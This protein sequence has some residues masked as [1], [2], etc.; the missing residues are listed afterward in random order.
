MTDK[1]Y[2]RVKNIRQAYSTCLGPRGDNLK[3]EIPDLKHIESGKGE[4]PRSE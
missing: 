3:V 1:C 4:R 2:E